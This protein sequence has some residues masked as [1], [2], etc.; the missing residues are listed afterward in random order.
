MATV[1]LLFQNKMHLILVTSTKSL[2]LTDSIFMNNARFLEGIL[3][4]TSQNMYPNNYFQIIN[5]SFKDL[6]PYSF[7]TENV[8]DIIIYNSYLKSQ[9]HYQSSIMI[10]NAKSVRLLNST[11]DILGLENSA[12]YFTTSLRCS[13]TMELLTLNSSFTKGKTTLN[14]NTSDFLRHAKSG[15]FIQTR[16]WFKMVQEETNYT[17]GKLKC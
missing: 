12:F 3:S 13:Y 16:W 4:V 7:R 5:C 14:T 10:K 2:I 17:S 15:K 1:V 9:P 8:R 6:G 11:F